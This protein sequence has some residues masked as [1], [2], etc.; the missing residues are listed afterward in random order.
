MYAVLL[1]LE[2]LFLGKLLSKKWVRPIGH[3][4]AL[5]VVIIGWVFFR[6]DDIVQAC[7]FIGKMF[8]AGTG[9]YSVFSFITVRAMIA[10]IAGIVLCFPIYRGIKSS[11]AK[12]PEKTRGALSVVETVWQIV[13]FAYSMIV[14]VSGSYNPFIYFQF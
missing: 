5:F 10:I 13:L 2:R 14:I 12:L 9:E 4:Y 8:T 11:V 3:I 1:M 6:S 7:K